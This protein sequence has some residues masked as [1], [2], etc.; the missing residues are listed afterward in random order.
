[1]GVDKSRRTIFAWSMYDFANQPYTTLIIT[2]I[3]ST[4]FAS[5]IS[6]NE[7]TGAALWSRAITITAISVA[8]L[9]PIMGAIADRGGY[10]KLFLIFWTFICILGSCAL[11]YPVPGEIYKALF[12]VVISNIGFEM[13]GVFCNAY[14]P[15]IA[16]KNKIGRISGYGWSLGY[17]GGLI[18][19]AVALFMFVQTPTPAFGVDKLQSPNR[20][21]VK[22]N[23]IV[24][25]GL[26][27]ESAKKSEIFEKI[28][29]A[30]GMSGQSENLEIPSGM[31]LQISK[32]GTTEKAQSISLN[33]SFVK[34]SNFDSLK[35]I[36]SYKKSRNK[37]NTIY[38]VGPWNQN[39]KSEN[40]RFIELDDGQYYEVRQPIYKENKLT[41]ILAYGEGGNFIVINESMCDEY[42][43]LDY[44]D[45]SELAH[46]STQNIRAINLM[47]AIWFIIFSIP[48]FLFVGDNN[49]IQK[50]Q[51]LKN[52][53]KDSFRQIKSTFTNI[54]EYKILVR[55]LIARLFYNDALITIF[56]FGGIYAKGQFG[57]TFND[58]LIFGIVLNV[59]AGLGSFFLGFLDDKIGG[60]KTIQLSNIGLIIACIIAVT[61]THDSFYFWLAG[62][63]IGVFSGPNQTASRSLMAKFIPEGK[64]NEFFGFFA[65]TGKATAFT[66]PLLLGLVAEAFQDLRLGISVV[67]VLFVI[68]FLLM[69]TVDEEA[70]F[71]Q[72]YR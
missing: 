17:L 44:K 70:G 7:I 37:D 14:L 51:S 68:G 69:N 66:G 22:F 8:F 9:S 25:D 33:N 28:R 23:K 43:K 39:Y 36:D 11:Y 32:K 27:I 2:F 10:R 42:E 45:I 5:V 30:L 55:F 61:L 46:G 6:E 18:S 52:L 60:K 34:L 16:P 40:Q 47:V 71:S 54:R 59:A 4:F 20:I 35:F 21:S 1:M 26:Y 64:E 67:I 19:L 72:K 53:W 58:I 49:S 50:P 31:Y 41:G 62:V 63:L 56:A 57:F 13:G 15:E 38:L 29:N 24:E 48:V 3:Y 12:W 65:F